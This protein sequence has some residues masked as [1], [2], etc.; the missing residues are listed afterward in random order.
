MKT[1]FARILLPAMLL[2]GMTARG[3]ET[4]YTSRIVNPSFET[5]GLEGW[6]NDGFQSQ[7]N[8]SPADAG[9]QKDGN[10]YAEKWV[11]ASNK[12]G[13]ASLHQI[14]TGLPNGQYVV[15]AVGHAINQNGNPP[16]TTGTY[17]YTR[18][19]QT[20]I[21]A[22]GEYEVTGTVA[23]G[24]LSIGIRTSGTDANWAAIDNFRIYRTGESAAEYR[25]YLD[26]IVAEFE[27]YVAGDRLRPD[28]YNKEQIAAAVAAAG[29]A[30]TTEQIM[31]A[32]KQLRRAESDYKA[33]V[34]AYK[35]TYYA[36]T[37][38]ASEIRIAESLRDDSDYPGKADFAAA[39]AAAKTDAAATGLSIAAGDAIIARLK[40]AT[41]TYL[42][43]R[44][45]QWVRISN[46]EM[47]RDDRGRDVQAHGA[48]FLLV[49]D[50][51][52]MIGED[53]SNSWNPD[54]NMYSSKD[55]VNWRW[56][57]KIIENGVTHPDLGSSRMIERPKL[58]YN[59]LTGNFVVWCHWEASNYG[60]SEAGV[61][62]SDVVNKPYT[63]YSGGR[64]M[65]IKSRDCNI[66]VDDDATAYF[67]STTSEN[68][69]L[70]LF[71]LSEDY[72]EPVEHTVLFAGQRREAPAIVKH[73]GL[74][75][76]LS[77]ACSGWDPNECKLAT[78][79]DLKTGWSGLR[80][81]GNPIAYDTQAASILKV[82]GSKTTTYLYV[83]DRW[84]DPSLPESKTIIFPIAF[85]GTGCTFEYV[86]EFEI[87]FAT[88]EW[89]AVDNS[90]SAID[91]SAFS[92]LDCSSEETAKEDGAAANI[93]DGDPATKWHTRY[94]SP[95]G[96]APHHVSIDMGASHRISALRIAPRTDT[97]STNG[98]IRDYAIQTSADG[99]AWTTVSAGSW[100][101]YW[102]EVRFH[103]TD[104]RYI[105]LV[106]FSGNYASVSDIEVFG[107]RADYTAVPL[108][109]AYK[110]DG[111]AWTAGGDITL[112]QG[113]SLTFGP[114]VDGTH[115]CW[116]LEC[117]DGTFR[118]G[119]E[120]TLDAMQPAQSGTYRA[121]FLDMYSTSH[122]TEYRVNVKADAGV[123][124][125]AVERTLLS[126]RYTT[127]Q[128]IA[129]D[130]PAPGAVY[131]VTDTYTDGY[132]HTYKFF[133]H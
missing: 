8:N 110:I 80:K 92:I 95:A 19:G 43:G 97:G 58:M 29:A 101:P 11:S 91:R 5:N 16:V 73:E 90:A 126:R 9:W 30:T 44:P 63:Y 65:G 14:V 108:T 72:L 1:I 68:T 99:S 116:A 83:G 77:S 52:Y 74:Y 127:L 2:A 120:V 76:M 130:N 78:T 4:D 62:Y 122:S 45:S 21:T 111:G 125:V 3:A 129:T 46:G 38:L 32:I 59:A 96:K 53:R 24:T 124:D 51:Y 13:D 34:E 42:A 40:A 48:G 105:R 39:I 69:N 113:Q 119:R 31:A 112:T 47:W 132:T 107:D 84:Q 106:S 89:R 57:C 70:G 128:G 33:L 133:V 94:S 10:V 60:A 27:A 131:I 102:G 12:L 56:E 71:R 54:V 15:R 93:L 98:L 25:K 66:Y 86:P 87:N 50:R 35:A 109:T 17:L 118:S 64:P 104:A 26:Y 88:G 117:P 28:D 20:L 61:F 41:K 79:A 100:L 55:L 18:M 82:E 22:A 81:V 49:G 85:D 36:K 121:H 7:T 37:R 115:G 67:I 75:Y 123:E 114:N 103:P 6:I 23:E